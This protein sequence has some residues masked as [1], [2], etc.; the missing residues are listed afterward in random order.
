MDSH[1]KVEAVGVG[2]ED[3]P[4]E[5][6]AEFKKEIARNVEA[7]KLMKEKEHEASMARERFVVSLPFPITCI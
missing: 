2:K 6:M 4:E 7:N 1:Q 3:I 5:M